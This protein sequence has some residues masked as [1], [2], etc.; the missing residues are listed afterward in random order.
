MTS[1]VDPSA[2]TVGEP[3]N[4]TY[5][6]TNPGTVALTDVLVASALP[7]GVNFVS[8]TQEWLG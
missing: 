1:S 6:V 8:A 2:A 7:G 5:T 4:F 3:V